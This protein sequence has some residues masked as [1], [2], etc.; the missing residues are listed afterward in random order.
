MSKFGLR[1]DADNL[2]ASIINCRVVVEFFNRVI[3]YLAVQSTHFIFLV[4]FLLLTLAASFA[5]A[6]WEE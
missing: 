6:S 5:H 3:N 1:F 2:V 4:H